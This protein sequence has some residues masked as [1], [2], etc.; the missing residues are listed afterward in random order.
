M[1]KEKVYKICHTYAEWDLVP[2]KE[3]TLQAMDIWAKEVAVEFA[4]WCMDNTC[5][6]MNLDNN[7]TYNPDFNG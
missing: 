3:S 1:D 2:N 4:K 5:Q 6:D 7:W